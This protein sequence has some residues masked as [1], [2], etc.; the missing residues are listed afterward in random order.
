MKKNILIIALTVF[1]ILCFSAFNVNARSIETAGFVEN[2]VAKEWTIMVYLNGDN[3][4]DSFG[5]KDINEMERI[6]SSD[7]VNIIVLQDRE[8]STARKLFITKDNDDNKVTSEVIEESGDID[9]GNAKNL[10]NFVAWCVK[11]YPAKNY[12]L[13]IWNHGSGWKKRQ[14]GISY[15]DQS[16]NHIS[17]AELGNAMA[18][19]YGIIGKKLDILLMDAC[20]MQMA[21]VV[22]EFKD[23]VKYCVASEETAP[24]DGYAYDL[25]MGPLTAEPFMDSR[26][27]SKLMAQSYIAYYNSNGKTATQ[28]VIDIGRLD[29]FVE[30]FNSLCRRM[31]ELTADDSFNNVIKRSV[32]PFTQSFYYTENIDLGHFLKVLQRNVKD[33]KLQTLISETLFLYA[34]GQNPLVIE[35]GASG[36]YTK[37]ITGLAIYFPESKPA[38]NYY[39]LKFARTN[40]ALFLD[41]FFKSII[42]NKKSGEKVKKSTPYNSD[43][44]Y[45]DCQGSSNDDSNDSFSSSASSAQS[46]GTDY[47]NPPAGGYYDD[48][49]SPSSSSSDDDSYS[50]SDSDSSDTDYSNPPADDYYGADGDESQYF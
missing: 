12:M 7:Q 37:N 17:T 25:F 48:H 38:S 4:L 18:S 28:S 23:Y 2:A 33:S 49:G 32:L 26:R 50:S 9:M 45:N 19:I 24:G 34:S 3:N 40:W 5:Y 16:G 39:N 20:L 10:V 47:S 31:V 44:D 14:R 11:K 29:D 30:K 35:N 6:G 43:P 41:N 22:Y 36:L 1:N 46:S 42:L 13:D 15:D 21:E 27:L 8:N